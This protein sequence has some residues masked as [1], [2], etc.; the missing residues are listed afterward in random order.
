MSASTVGLLA[1]LYE[2]G[3]RPS[4]GDVRRAGEES[5]AFGV[6][7]DPGEHEDWAELLITGLTFE[8]A[9]LVPGE[10]APAP[11]IAH[12]FGLD[13]AWPASA[14]EAIVVRP[15]VHLA[16]AAAMLPVVRGAAALAAALADR[17]AAAA[18]V[19][20]PSRSA[21]G[22]DYFASVIADWLA[23][24]AFPALGMIALVPSA[25]G[26][27]SEGLGFFTGQELDVETAEGRDIAQAGR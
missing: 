5:G 2:A 18:A 4:I 17:T 22:A 19:W 15:G 6:S 16:G 25:T 3:R 7:F 23:G 21:M 14:L 11:E 20:I 26:I 27:V 1:L 12:R 13:G 24:G 10:A 9:G 8:V